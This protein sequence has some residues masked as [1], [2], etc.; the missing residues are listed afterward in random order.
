MEIKGKFFKSLLDTPDNNYKV[1]KYKATT[2]AV[3]LFGKNASYFTAVGI[4]LPTA[5]NIEYSFNGIWEVDKK[6]REQFKVESY[7]EVIPTEKDG[8]IKYLKTLDGI[9]KNNALLLYNYYGEDIFN[10]L[11]NNI[12][13]VKESGLSTRAFNKLKPCWLQKRTGKE[14]YSYMLS[15]DIP[16][17]V[18]TK[19]YEKYEEFALNIAKQNPYSLIQIKG[20]SFYMADK[21]AMANHVDMFNHVRIEA[22]ILAAIKEYENGGKLLSQ[23]NHSHN[24]FIQPGNTCITWELLYELVRELLNIDISAQMLGEIVL[25]MENKDIVIDDDNYFFRRDTA[26]REKGIAK[27]VKRLLSNKDDLSL[28][29]N[30]KS[31]M[32]MQ[33]ELISL[34]GL[35]GKLSEEQCKA[36][37]TCL[38]NQLSII[39]GGPG[40]GKTM[41]QKAILYIMR[42]RV[43]NAQI[44]LAAPSGRAARRMS[45][46]T[47]YPASTIHSMLGLYADEENKSIEKLE[48]DLVIIDEFSMVDTRLANYL[49][50][51]IGDNTKIVC[52]GDDKQ[53]PSVDYGAVLRELMSSGEVP[54]AVL[55][56]VYRQKSGSSISYNASRI[57]VGNPDMHLDKTFEFH[58]AKSSKAILELVEELYEEYISEYG[59]DNVCVLSPYKNKTI[60]GVNELNKKLQHIAFPDA[61][62][63]EVLFLEGDKVMYTKND[64]DLTNGDIGRVV[65]CRKDAFGISVTVDFGDGR[66]ATLEDEAV[67]SLQLAYSTTVHKSQGSEYKIVIMVIDPEHKIMLRRNLI[68]TAVTRAKQKLIIVG[69][70]DAF[71]AGIAKEETTVRLSRLGHFIQ[72]LN[73]SEKKKTELNGEQLSLNI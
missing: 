42:T 38:N 5:K 57:N 33:D 52:I 70:K 47:G 68:Y 3:T 32:D 28:G 10:V 23:Y 56:N 49:F 13:S 66:V 69:S 17:A 26:R 40:T 22:A 46:S 21:L 24:T 43:K 12:D 25:R 67:N 54:T 44:L 11:D 60:T 71:A 62:T 18:V 2:E 64:N 6:G 29:L 45:E 31:I 58:E 9:T 63:S 59:L 34:G 65:S 48:A 15:F 19:I 51:A 30:V 16:K 50:S 39:T 4:D 36:V 61:D 8:I 53:L 7:E 72:T 41:I 20:F 27:N 14:F 35:P 73:K 1:I 37:C 55:T